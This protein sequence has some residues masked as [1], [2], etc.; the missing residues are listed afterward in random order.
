[1][2]SV[3]QPTEPAP[4]PQHIAIIMDGNG[5]WAQERGLPR[6]AGHTRGAEAVREAVTGALEL[7]VP[8]LTL[9]GFSLE[10]WKR[11][12]TEVGDL[13]RLLQHYLKR[14]MRQLFEK[15]VRVR[16]IGDRALLPD[17]IVG[18]IENAEETTR[19]NSR[20]HLTIALSYGSRQEILSAVRDIA[21][22]VRDGRVDPDS[23]SEETVAG[24]LFT[25]ELPDPDL[26]IRTSGEQRVSNFLLWQLAYSEMLFVDTYWPDFKKESLQSAVDE[27]NRRERRYGMTLA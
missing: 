4:P 14:E 25:H 27:F 3:P 5:R 8:Y 26:I 13:M 15:G 17:S 19:G 1:M 16:F 6:T 21:Q 9:F 11:P 2:K 23:I 7:G 22:D 12:S 18:T 20:L 24:R 10:N